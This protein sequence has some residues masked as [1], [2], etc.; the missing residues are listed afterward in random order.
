MA[1]PQYPK[2]YDH[3]VIITPKQHLSAEK[4]NY[5]DFKPPKSVI[6]CFES[7]VIDHYKNLDNTEHSHFWTGEMIY[8]KDYN[9][10]VAIVG[11]FG[12]GG[13][14]AS[15]I[16]EILIAVGVKNFIVI[17]HAGGLQK[18]NPIR[19]IVLIDKSIRDEGVSHHYLAPEKYAF[20]SLSLTDK[21]KN[22]LDNEAIDYKVGSS[23]TI[24]SMYRETKEEIAH[25]AQEGIATV[26]MELA[27]LFA[28]AMFRKVDIASL[29]VI[30]DY[31]AFTN[32]DEH[33]NSDLTSRALF[34]AIE[35]AEKVLFE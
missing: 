1:F 34:K 9:N 17:G 25:Y 21:L 8:L 26:E 19:T 15:H 12:I 6:L 27:S 30:S 10:E 2:K 22:R 24:A 29:L 33:L 14:A 4:K 7:S 13:A 31:V 28:V 23:W 20:P 32:W 5:K 35:I 11:N 18:N 3:K 16:L